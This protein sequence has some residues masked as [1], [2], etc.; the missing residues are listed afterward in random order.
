MTKR[1]LRPVIVGG[2]D[3]KFI[4]RSSGNSLGLLFI[5]FSF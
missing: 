4:I 1:V 3:E 2:R 5:M